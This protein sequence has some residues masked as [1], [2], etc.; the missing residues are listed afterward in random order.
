MIRGTYGL[1]RQV[2]FGSSP[3]MDVIRILHV[4]D[5]PRDAELVQRVVEAG[6]FEIE[7][8]RVDNAG[9]MDVA[10]SER[11]WDVVL[12]DCNMPSFDGFG[13]LDTLHKHGHDIPLIVVSGTIRDEMAVALMKAGAADYV[14]KDDLTRLTPA[15]LREVTDAEHRRARRLAEAQL[16][17]RERMLSTAQRIAHLGSW[18]RNYKAQTL[19]WSEELY[20]ILGHTPDYQPSTH[21]S[22]VDVAHP[23]DRERVAE[24]LASALEQGRIV[25]LEHR[26]K[27]FDGQSRWVYC[28]MEPERDEAGQPIRLFGTVLDITERKQSEEAIRFQ[29]HLLDTVEQAVV[30][31]DT[32]GQ[33][34]YWNRFAETLYGWREEEAIGRLALDLML[35]GESDEQALEIYSRLERGE[36]WTGEVY[37]H[38]RRGES[39][40]AHTSISH[41]YD[42]DGNLIGFVGLS[43]DTTERR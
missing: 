9:A 21:G 17:E 26:I 8:Q 5:S 1:W 22:Y 29:A 23:D 42:T 37:V 25:A 33:I 27:R 34:V 39:F 2:R 32:V 13:A 3:P 14:V 11:P 24:A 38:H 20:A 19:W 35:A 40:W 36:S 16:V 43:F 4:E 41:I 12:V 7:S 18:E 10:L 31:T 28:R 30:A 15:I 6:G